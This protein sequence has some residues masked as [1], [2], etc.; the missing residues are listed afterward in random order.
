MTPQFSPEFQLSVACAMWPPSEHRIEAIRTAVA[1]PLDWPRFTRVARRHQV[2]GLVD[3]GLRYARSGV[4]PQIIDEIDAE[5]TTLIPKN[6][7]MAAEALRLQRLF[8]EANLT[9]LFV[10]GAALAE[11]A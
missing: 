3:E 1:G 6:L 5:A 4:P 11:L 7:A 2:I 10:K 9:V 8:N